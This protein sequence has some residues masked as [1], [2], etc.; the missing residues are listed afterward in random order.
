M[1]RHWSGLRFRR[2]VLPAC[3][4]SVMIAGAALTA[5]TPPTAQGA[6]QAEALAPQQLENLVAP[7]ALYADPLVSQVL[8]AST[9]PLELVE[10]QQWVQSNPDLKGQDLVEA[11]KQKNWDASVQALVA[12]PEVLSRL[13]QN[14]QWT[15]DL[16]NAFLAQQ[17]D[18]MSA[19]QRMRS[20]AQAAGKLESDSH[21]T[22]TTERQDGQAA[23]Q[24]MPAEPQV[25]YVPTYDPAYVW[26]P[27]AWGDYPPLWYPSY[28]WGWGWGINIGF[29]FGG[30]GGWGWGGWG[31]GWGPSWYGGGVYTNS[32]FFGHYHYAHSGYGYGHGHD[33]G[34]NGHNG[35][36]HRRPGPTA[37]TT[38]WTHDPSHRQGVGYPNASLNSRYGAASTAARR[39]GGQT[40]SGRNYTSGVV[41]NRTSPGNGVPGTGSRSAAA[42]GASNGW[43]SFSE[44]N[45]ASRGATP[46]TGTHAGVS[47]GQSPA[48]TTGSRSSNSSAIANRGSGWS[49]GPAAGARSPQSSATASGARSFSEGAAANHGATWSTGS[50][51]A[52][53]GPRSSGTTPGWNSFNGST[54]NRGSGWNTGSMASGR[55]YQSPGGSNWSTGSRASANYAYRGGAYGGR[56]YTGSSQSY[57]AAPRAYSAPA[58]GSRGAYPGYGGGYSRGYAGGYSGGSHSSG[59]Y[60][61]GGYHGSGGGSASSHAFSGGGG[62]GFHGGGGGGHSGHR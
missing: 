20:R 11:A 25:I 17:A 43:H 3:V 30:W 50:R 58:M 51:A 42:M 10:A 26:G 40:G 56:G 62:G 53:G 41:G 9:Y 60:S 39:S 47:T 32:I 22:V 16:G 24:I 8:V 29:C 4:V 14:I 38:A 27:P 21:Q 6:T 7:I 34:G 48:G 59:G 19:I 28:G 2:L 18:V 12:M 61:G 52:A 31:W 15:T 45:T 57:A 44:G 35:G 23:I 33:G 54:A 1:N 55:S 49:T 37:G 5:Q 46:G 13:T 36:G